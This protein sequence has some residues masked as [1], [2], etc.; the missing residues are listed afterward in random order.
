MGE[1]YSAQVQYSIF[2]GPLVKYIFINI[3]RCE[4]FI[5]PNQIK[6]FILYSYKCIIYLTY[7]VIFKTV[8]VLLLP[9]THFNII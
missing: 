3:F 9:F 8:M 2:V 5:I 7:I 4:Y 6:P 1:V